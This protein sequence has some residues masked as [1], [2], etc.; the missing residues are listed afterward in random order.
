M[1]TSMFTSCRK[2]TVE[3]LPTLDILKIH[4]KK[5]CLIRE[6]FNMMRA[7]FRKCLASNQLLPRKP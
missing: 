5:I 2:G 3:Y 6:K 1:P 4:S 7:N